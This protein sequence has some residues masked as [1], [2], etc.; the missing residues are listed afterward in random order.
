[1]KYKGT[2]SIYKYPSHIHNIRCPKCTKIYGYAKSTCDFC[3][4][5]GS[6][7]YMNGPHSLQQLPHDEAEW[8]K[9]EEYNA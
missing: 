9:K 6:V 7:P 3:D 8:C 2:T 5:Y 4:G 1:M